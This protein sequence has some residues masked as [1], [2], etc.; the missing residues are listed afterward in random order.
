MSYRFTFPETTLSDGRRGAMF[1]DYG[2]DIARGV[3]QYRAAFC[4]EFPMP[5]GETDLAAHFVAVARDFPLVTMVDPGTGFD[6]LRVGNVPFDPEYKRF[7]IL[8]DPRGNSII[9]KL[10][11]RDRQERASADRPEPARPDNKNN[12]KKKNQRRRL[13]RRAKAHRA[14]AAPTVV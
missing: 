8:I 10:V 6:C 9:A 7:N 1:F 11:A 12:T 2:P 14:A 13:R 3:A 5:E 4:N